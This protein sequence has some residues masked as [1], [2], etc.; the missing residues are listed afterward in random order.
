M[1]KEVKPGP[2][3]DSMYAEL[4][5]VLIKYKDKVTLEARL[6]ALSGMVGKLLAFVDPQLM[7]T[8]Q[9]MEVVLRNMEAGNKAAMDAFWEPRGNA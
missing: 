7:T 3:Y 8:D 5:D 1:I 2:D 6:A 9:A 4:A